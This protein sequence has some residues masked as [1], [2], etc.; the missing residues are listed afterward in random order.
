MYYRHPLDN[1]GRASDEVSKAFYERQAELEHEDMVA[2]G[3]HNIVLSAWCPPEN[4]AGQYEADWTL[5]QAKLDLCRHTATGRTHINARR[6]HRS[7]WAQAGA[8]RGREVP[9][10]DTPKY[11]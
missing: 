11:A 5:P 2:H 3:M 6:D 4:E 10:P 7:T 8:P 1:A 9:P